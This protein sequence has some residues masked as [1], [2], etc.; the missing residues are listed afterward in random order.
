MGTP[1]NLVEV[2][3]RDLEGNL[4]EGGQVGEICIRGPNVTKGYWN[5]PEES[6]WVPTTSY[7]TPTSIQQPRVIRFGARFSF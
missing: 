3:I 7:K 4:L 5:H 2:Q 6:E 1:A